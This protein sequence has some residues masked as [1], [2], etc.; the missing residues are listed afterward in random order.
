LQERN[1]ERGF[2]FTDLLA[3]SRLRNVNCPRRLRKAARLDNSYK[4]I[5]MAV[6]HPTT[7]I[8]TKP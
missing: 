8:G 1:A 2:Q 3:E 6:M 4:I 5:E 7:L